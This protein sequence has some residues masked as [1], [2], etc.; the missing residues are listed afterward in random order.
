MCKAIINGSILKKSNYYVY[1]NNNS[2]AVSFIDDIEGSGIDDV[3]D[4]SIID[5]D[6]ID[7]INCYYYYWP[8]IG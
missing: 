5:D 6:S 1:I 2:K 7:S 8:S 4:D 3:I